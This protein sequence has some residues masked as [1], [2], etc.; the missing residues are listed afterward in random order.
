MAHDDHR[1][2]RM[3]GRAAA[4]LLTGALAGP[5]IAAED[6]GQDTAP[7]TDEVRDADEATV[8]RHV[9][10]DRV[11]QEE[12]HKQQVREGADHQELATD[13]G[14]SADDEDAETD[15][16]EDAAPAVQERDARRGTRQ[17][18]ATKQQQQQRSRQR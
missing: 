1:S 15:E 14:E 2:A 10:R 3:A 11:R 9:D 12:R 17:E 5:A 7:S 6:E 16:L 8:D 18:A 4:L 13:E